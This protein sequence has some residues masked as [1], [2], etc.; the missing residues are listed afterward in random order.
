MIYYRE[1]PNRWRG[2]GTYHPKEPSTS[3]LRFIMTGLIVTLMLIATWVCDEVWPVPDSVMP[4]IVKQ[5]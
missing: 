4:P 1:P 2:S 3:T 5:K